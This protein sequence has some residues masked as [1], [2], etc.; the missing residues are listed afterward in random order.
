MAPAD[1]NMGWLLHVS[2][3]L[4]CIPFVLLILVSMVCRTSS[5]TGHITELNSANFDKIITS[6]EVVFVNF[7]ANWCRFS[8]MLKPVIEET[9]KA[10]KEEFREPGQVVVAALDCQR[11][12]ALAKKY[13]ITKYPTLKMFRNGQLAKREYRAQRSKDAFVKYLKEQMADPIVRMQ[14][15]D[16][17]KKIDESKRNI[18]AYFKSPNTNEYAI[19]RRTASSLR[20]DCSFY[21]GV[22]DNFKSDT[23]S[24]DNIMFRPP[25]T[26]D[27][28]MLY[29]GSMLNFNLLHTW[30]SDKCIPLVREI[31]FENGEELTEEGLPFLILFHKPDDVDIVKRFN[32]IISREL[33]GDKG[34]VNFLTADGTKFS[35][36]L[37]H[38]GK[39]AK[40]LPLIAID[41]F[42][43]MYLFPNVQELDV[44]GKLKQLIQDL[45]SGKLHREFHHGPDKQDPNK[46]IVQGTVGSK[47]AG[48]DDSTDPPESTFV[49]L[50][51]STNRYSFRDEL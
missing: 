17:L 24:G 11:E 9:A 46:Q 42:R 18:I 45:H 25:R 12:D 32:N 3:L 35:H 51:P 10:V 19:L 1:S 33:V 15:Q 38:L 16:D 34:S 40:D 50:K 4:K 21:V 41:S 26:K 20:D 8:Q 37:H 6:N 31:T 27:Q 36:P 13:H 5:Q 28:D 2:M 7:Y 23:V 47:T 44:S 14:T 29:L 22:G 48:K 30:A 43:H 39:T 49:K